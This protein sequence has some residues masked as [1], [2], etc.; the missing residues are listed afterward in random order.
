M[1]PHFIKQTQ[2][3]ISRLRQKI[4]CLILPSA[5]CWKIMA[6]DRWSVTPDVTLVGSP[7]T[8]ALASPRAAIPRVLLRKDELLILASQP[9]LLGMP[10]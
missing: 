9:P 2:K 7:S 6:R 5:T 10:C 4:R 8:S 3:A 1:C